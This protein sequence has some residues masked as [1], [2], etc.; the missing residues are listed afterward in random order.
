MVST[1]NNKRNLR[2]QIQSSS[3]AKYATRQYIKKFGIKFDSLPEYL[4]ARICSVYSNQLEKVSGCG[5]WHFS[6]LVTMLGKE[7]NGYGLIN[8]SLIAGG[9][10]Q[11]TIGRCELFNPEALENNRKGTVTITDNAI[12]SLLYESNG[13]ESLSSANT[14]RYLGYLLDS[15]EKKSCEIPDIYL[16][17]SDTKTERT[18]MNLLDDHN[19]SYANIR[20][21]YASKNA[22][23]SM[24]SGFKAIYDSYLNDRNASFAA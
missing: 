7:G 2:K 11:I 14:G 9:I 5:V 20:T 4:Q 17:Y 24:L 16:A 10:R 19:I 21:G 23:T 1:E 8:P 15:M 22:G 18:V 13:I 3:N 6:G 12:L